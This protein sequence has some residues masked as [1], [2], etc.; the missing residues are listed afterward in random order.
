MLDL[1]CKLLKRTQ[2][3]GMTSIFEED[4]TTLVA[5]FFDDQLFEIFK[6]GLQLVPGAS[7]YDEDTGNYLVG[8]LGE[9][10]AF[11]GYADD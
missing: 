3:H 9:L 2:Y 8:N 1:P 10:I 7:L 11:R 5:N 6:A 4:G